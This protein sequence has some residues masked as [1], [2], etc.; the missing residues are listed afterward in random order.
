M[1]V[2]MKTRQR[3]GSVYL[4]TF[5]TVGAITS[6]ALIGMS[7]RQTA[8]TK[9]VI[10]TDM[11]I[12]TENMN[13]STEF[14]IETLASDMIW[15]KTASTGTV[16]TSKQIGNQLVSATVL[17]ADTLSVP[18]EKTANYQITMSSDYQSVHREARFDCTVAKTYLPLLSSLG[19]EEYWALDE[20]NGVSKATESVSG[21]HGDFLDP[22]IVGGSAYPSG[23]STPSFHASNDEVQIDYSKNFKLSDG[24]LSFWIKLTSSDNFQAFGIA[25]MLYKAGGRPTLSLGI[26]GGGVHFYID[27]DGIYSSDHFAS[28]SGSLIT[29]DTWHHVAVTWGAGGQTVAVDGVLRA[30][31]KLNVDG[32][33]TASAS[34]GG[35]QPLRF[36]AGY[37]VSRYTQ[38]KVGFE[39][40]IAR[41]SLYPTQLTI[42]QIARLAEIDPDEQRVTIIDDTWERIFD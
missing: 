19:A 41:V 16:F 35:K 10:I 39:G 12:G 24:T 37:L 31:E 18:G 6:M 25:G 4:V 36:G 29:K 13:S 32:F 42:E 28:T 22:G 2:L 5:V 17:D 40:S 30:W 26:M 11:S 38:S 23:L 20:P 34:K 8:R 21:V 14:V 7:L 3:R 9:T 33:G 1:G 15:A 27:E